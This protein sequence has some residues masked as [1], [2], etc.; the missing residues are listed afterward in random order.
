MRETCAISATIA[1][2]V[3]RLMPKGSSPIRASPDSFR[4]IRLY[5]GSQCAFPACAMTSAAKSVDF[6]SMPS[7]TTKKA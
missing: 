2:M 1:S 6:F 4:R 5:F 7:P 3:G